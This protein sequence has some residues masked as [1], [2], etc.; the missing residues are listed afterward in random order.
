MISAR[1]R[2]ISSPEAP[3]SWRA[4]QQRD[5]VLQKQ[6]CTPPAGRPAELS[7][8]NAEV[9]LGALLEGLRH[10]FNRRLPADRLPDRGALLEE[11]GHVGEGHHVRPVAEGACGVRVGLNEQAVGARGERRAGQRQGELAL[12]A[13]AAGA[14]AG[15]LD[16]VR[17]VEDRRA[18]RSGP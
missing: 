5:L 12:A 17:R 13:A 2:A 10:G 14:G 15:Q 9:G 7:A 16:A 8:P 18:A 11:F 3:A 4:L 6:P 1:P